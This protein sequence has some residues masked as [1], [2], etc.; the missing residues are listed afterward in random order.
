MVGMIA[1]FFAEGIGQAPRL[2]PSRSG[3][4]LTDLMQQQRVGHSVGAAALCACENAAGLQATLQIR[5]TTIQVATCRNRAVTVD[6]T[7]DGLYR[8][9][10]YGRRVHAQRHSLDYT[11]TEVN[12]GDA[13]ILHLPGEIFVETAKA[14]RAANPDRRVV[15]VSGPSADIGYLATATAHQEGGMEPQYAGLAPEAEEQIRRAACELIAAPAADRLA[16]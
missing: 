15:V 14:I 6:E 7:Q 16:S 12:L 2:T 1:R 4:R 9:Q 13:S 5:S 3:R 8:H 11:L 10:A